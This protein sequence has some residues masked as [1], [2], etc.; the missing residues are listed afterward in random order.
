MAMFASGWEMP[1]NV[2]IGT[3]SVY[4]VLA[5]SAAIVHRLLDQTHQRGCGQ[6]PPLIKCPLV[7]RERIG[8]AGQH[9]AAVGGGRVDPGHRQP[10]DVVDPGRG[11]CRRSIA[12]PRRR[13]A[14]R[15]GRRSTRCGIS[16]TPVEVSSSCGSSAGDLLAVDQ[17]GVRRLQSAQRGRAAVRHR[18]G[19]STVPAPARGRASSATSVRSTSV[20]PSPPTDSGSAIVVAPMAHNRSHRLLSKPVGSAARTVSIGH[21]ALKNFEYA[22]C[23]S[24]WSLGQ[25]VVESAQFVTVHSS[26]LLGVAGTEEEFAARCCTDSSRGRRRADRAPAPRAPRD[27]CGSTGQSDAKITLF[28]PARAHVVQQAFPAA[29]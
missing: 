12:R 3:P 13:R 11:G 8:A 16:R 7:I 19:R 5:N 28:G 24:T 9:R 26:A 6:H 4:R 20:A 22:A 14:R 18:R 25:A 27:A 17:V 15:C 2:E 29:A 23:R 1:C 21:C 10:A